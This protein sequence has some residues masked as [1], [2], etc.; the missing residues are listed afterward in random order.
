MKECIELVAK[1]HYNLAQ[2]NAIQPL[3]QGMFT[4]DKKGVIAI[5]PA[6]L[7]RSDSNSILGLKTVSVFHNNVKIGLPL[8]KTA[9]CQLK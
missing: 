5:M 3:R 6:F 1:A 2:G 8:R 4:L 9:T 7:G